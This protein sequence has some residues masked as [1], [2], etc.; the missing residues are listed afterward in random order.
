MSALVWPRLAEPRV[1][2]DPS[3]RARRA[4]SRLTASLYEPRREGFGRWLRRL[5]AYGLWLF[6]LLRQK[7]WQLGVA[8]GVE[9][10][11]AENVPQDSRA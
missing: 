8:D 6:F 1:R 11:V 9:C 5:M 4:T 7:Q 10:R 2:S 3:R